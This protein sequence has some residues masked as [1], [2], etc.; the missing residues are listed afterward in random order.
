MH[1]WP[2]SGIMEVNNEIIL[3][4]LAQADNNWQPPEVS[5]INSVPTGDMPGDKI[6]IKHIHKQKANV[7]FPVLMHKLR[8]ALAGG[9]Q[10]AVIA[11]HGGSGVGK[12]A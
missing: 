6:D 12:S 1:R 7:I 2:G 3:K 4:L 10:K 9:N 5:D 8:D 11:V